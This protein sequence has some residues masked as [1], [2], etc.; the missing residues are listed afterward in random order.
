[1]SP[2]GQRS[3]INERFGNGAGP[4]GV[5]FLGG[6][7]HRQG[8][9]LAILQKSAGQI[10]VRIDDVC[11]V[12]ST[13]AFMGD[14]GTLEVD[15]GDLASGGE[16]SERLGTG[17]QHVGRRSHA[18]GN[19]GRCA[20]AAVFLDSDERCLGC[21]RV[22]ERLATTAVA[23]HIDETGQE[24]RIGGLGKLTVIVGYGAG[25]S[26]SRAVNLDNSVINNGVFEDQA[27]A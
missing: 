4:I 2:R 5:R 6:K 12:L 22:R 19:E 21:L 8:V 10:R 14:E 26:N 25:T 11:R 16:L 20:M 15:A 7:G 18:R 23:V 17:A 24:C 9:P 3:P 1:M 27:A 13:A